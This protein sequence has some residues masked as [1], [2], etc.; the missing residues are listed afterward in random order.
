MM[1]GK[2]TFDDHVNAL[3]RYWKGENIYFIHI[4]K[5]LMALFPKSRVIKVLVGPGT[6]LDLQPEKSPKIGF[7]TRD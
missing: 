4:Y 7:L 1:L 2:V 6:D 5:T 3:A